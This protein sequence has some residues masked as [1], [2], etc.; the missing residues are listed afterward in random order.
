VDRPN[1]TDGVVTLRPSRPEDADAL[2]EACQDPEV[3]R[4]SLVLP[5][6]YEREHAVE[7]IARSAEDAA[8]GRAWHL[9]AVDDD[10]RVIGAFSVM[11]GELGYWL[12]PA[13]RGRGVATRAVTMLRDWAHAALGRRRLELL[14]HPDNAP[15]R[16]VA[17]RAGF[18]DT[19]VR[20]I[21]PRGDD[22]DPHAVYEW[23]AP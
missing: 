16:R 2:T 11:G 7:F 10:D 21:P 13:A 20:R 5:W 14:I 15:S 1:L 8:A 6:P 18:V 9:V 23:R 12:A 4:W 17:Q 19:G 22:P 3:Q